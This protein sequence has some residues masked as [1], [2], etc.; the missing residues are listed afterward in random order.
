LRLPLLAAQTHVLLHDALSVLDR[1]TAALFHARV[2]DALL[3]QTDTTQ[4]AFTFYAWVDEQEVAHTV[5]RANLHV[6]AVRSIATSLNHLALYT[7]GA[8]TIQ[9]AARLPGARQHPQLWQPHLLRDHLSAAGRDPHISASDLL[10][11]R[12]R[13]DQLA[14]QTHDDLGVFLVDISLGRAYL[15]R[16]Q[17]D[18]GATLL[19]NAHDQL[20]SLRQVGP[21]HRA[22]LAARLATLYR[23]RGDFSLWQETLVEALTLA[24]QAGLV[25]VERDIRT[26]HGRLPAFARVLEAVGPPVTVASAAH[27]AH[28]D[29]HE[30]K[31]EIA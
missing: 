20:A 17:L 10:D 13:A 6:N 18:T 22:M 25:R 29:W 1:P 27:A 3:E 8:F 12:R 9:R 26:E 19:R 24:R 14:E 2:A 4:T 23:L 16:G 5:L 28:P 11:F 30:T 15:L 7:E 21:L 31:R